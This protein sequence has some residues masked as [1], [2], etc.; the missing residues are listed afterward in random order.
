MTIE[1][2]RF[3]RRGRAAIVPAALILLAVLHPAR[4][5]DVTPLRG[6]HIVFVEPYGPDSVTNFPLALM[7]DEIARKSGAA[8]D[9]VPIGGKAGGSAVD[10][11][12]SPPPAIAEDAIVFAVLDI[13]SRQLA[14]S[15]AGRPKFLQSLQPVATLSGALSAALVVAAGSDIRTVDDLL[16]RARAK[17]LKIVGLGRRAAFGIELAML[18]KA[19]GLT[20]DETIVSTRAEILAALASGEA[21]AGFLVTLTLLPSSQAAAPPVRPILTFAAKR[22]PGFP[23]IPTFKESIAK[24]KKGAAIASAI[25]VFAP[26]RTPQPVVA[27]MAS[28][29]REIADEPEIKQAAASRNYPLAVAPAATASEEMARIARMIKQHQAYLDR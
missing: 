18:E 22:N 11:V 24:D 3:Q 29:L 9:I 2:V 7:R 1:F 26:L 13:V 8:V 27:A 14:E 19:S 23:Q 4:A 25:A 6:K 15:A 21:D 5:A 17:P 28:L 12:L 16:A 10:Y 20:L